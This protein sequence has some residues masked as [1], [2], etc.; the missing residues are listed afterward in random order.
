LAILL[1]PASPADVPALETLIAASARG[2]GG[3]HYS[4]AQTEAAIA[5]VFEVDTELVA[6]GSYLVAEVAG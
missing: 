2:L 5:H 3:G 6:D 4:T 1:R